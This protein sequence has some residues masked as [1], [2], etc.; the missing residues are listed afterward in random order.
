[1]GLLSKLGDGR[2]KKLVEFMEPQLQGDEEIQAAVPMTQT[3][4][5]MF[6]GVA[7]VSFFGLALTDRNLYLVRWGKGL[8]E[9]PEEIMATLPRSS[10]TVA[11]WSRGFTTSKLELRGGEDV[12][13]LDV[14]G[15]HKK[16]GEELV[17]ALPQAQ[18][19][20]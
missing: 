20:A 7:L 16:D 3:G 15:M 17:A 6:M 18:P 10:V 1:V 19:A 9:R 12:L 8:P 5:P 13:K 2:R 4:N 14:P 11:N